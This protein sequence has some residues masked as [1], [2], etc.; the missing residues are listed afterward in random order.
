MGGAEHLLPSTP[1]ESQFLGLPACLPA[2]QLPASEQPKKKWALHSSTAPHADDADAGTIAVGCWGRVDCGW[3]GNARLRSGVAPLFVSRALAPMSPTSSSSSGDVTQVQRRIAALD[4]R[5]HHTLQDTRP[6]LTS[7]C[8]QSRDR[9]RLP[10]LHARSQS[11][12]SR[13]FVVANTCALFIF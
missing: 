4:R 13:L 5:H 1:F 2:C 12:G 3:G 11:L 7:M 9:D 8:V 6:S 10:R